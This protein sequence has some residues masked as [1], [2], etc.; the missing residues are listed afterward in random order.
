MQLPLTQEEF[1]QIN[2]LYQKISGLYLTSITSH[3]P[4]VRGL[5]NGPDKDW[6]QILEQRIP[7]DFPLTDG[8]PIAD[9]DQLFLTDR[10]RL[11]K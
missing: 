4:Y 6:F 10:E 2:D 7:A 3:K 8:F 9:M 5:K 11:V 1:Y